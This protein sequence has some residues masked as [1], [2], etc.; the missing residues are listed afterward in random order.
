[1]AERTLARWARRDQTA[2]PSQYIGIDDEIAD[3]IPPHV[4]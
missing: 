3:E 1:L 4:A 2:A